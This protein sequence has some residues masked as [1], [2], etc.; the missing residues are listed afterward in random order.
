MINLNRF[1]CLCDWWDDWYMMTIKDWGLS[2]KIRTPINFSTLHGPIDFWI[3]FDHINFQN[4]CW[5]THS[6]SSV[7]PS[8]SLCVFFHNSLLITKSWIILSEKTINRNRYCLSGLD[9]FMKSKI[10]TL[11]LWRKFKLCVQRNLL[12]WGFISPFQ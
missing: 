12:H 8:L 11:S 2:I 10:K 6:I 3:S 9:D 1:K 7:F 4:Q 5:W